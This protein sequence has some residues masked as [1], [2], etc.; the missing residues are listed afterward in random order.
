MTGAR[1]ADRD[2]D[3]RTAPRRRSM[4]ERISWL[5]VA[6]TTISVP[7][8]LS[9]S[10]KDSFRVPKELLLKAGGILLLALAICELLIDGRYGR[11]NEW[12]PAVVDVIGAALIWCAVITIRSTNRML[13]LESL[14]YVAAAIM[15]FV[16]TYRGARGRSI[17]IL[18][19]VL[20]PALINALMA[21][22]QRTTIWTPITFDATYTGR[23]GTTALLGNPDDVG[24]FLTAPTVAA[25]AL[26]LTSKDRRWKAIAMMVI[27]IVAIVASESA[28]A[29][30]AV[31]V[32][33]FLLVFLV[34][35]HM[36]IAGGVLCL[37]LATL[38]IRI[39]TE[40]WSLTQS[41]IASAARGDIDPL[42]S[43]RLPAFMAAWRMFE[44]HPMLGVGLGCFS[45]EYFDEKI[46]VEM[47][48]PWL[49]NRSVVNFGEVHNE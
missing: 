9:A 7:L 49:S 13:S 33:L 46:A 38:F 2:S 42:L 4:T 37:L 6:L 32:G 39:S 48:H 47:E 36:A 41:K 25:A 12:S 5:I 29:I 31:F 20:A 8:F 10:A 43:G 35:P 28:S 14:V 30:I 22:A 40:R 21:I 3:H 19:F 23:L 16:A 26:A 17:S 15:F 24:M 1:A 18:Y 45:F 34:R 27:L 44:H 11:K